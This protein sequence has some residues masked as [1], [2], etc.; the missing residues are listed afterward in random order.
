MKNALKRLGAYFI[1]LVIVYFISAL[2]SSF[3]I[4]GT[5]YD[6]Y[7]NTYNDYVNFIEIYDNF[8]GDLKKYYN[9][10]ELTEE[11]YN[12]IKD[13]YQEIAI[14]LDEAYS[15]K[16]LSKKEYN[17]IVNNALDEYENL[18]IHKQYKMSKMNIV[19]TVVTIIMMIV[20]FVIIQ[21][22]RRGQTFGKKILKIKVYS[23]DGNR[24]TINNLLLRSLIITD[25]I[26][27]SIRIYCLYNMD[28]YGYN[29]ASF[30]LS[31]IMYLVLFISLLFVVYRRDHKSLQDLFAGTKVVI[32]R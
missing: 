17:S 6:K 24:P 14:G 13:K 3:I 32:D 7:L 16:K 9:D 31:N 12:K 30:I 20:Y 27:S 15:D 21:Y 29:N 1:D 26:W 4:A 25:I 10:N 22:F 19:N 5:N 28:A 23:K 11:E 2:I 8:F 18:A